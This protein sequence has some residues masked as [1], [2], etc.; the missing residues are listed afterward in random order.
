M[1]LHLKNFGLH[2]QKT[3]EF[4]EK[5]TVLLSGVSGK[6]KTTIFRAIHF[7]LTGESKM[8]THGETKSAVTLEYFH[9]GKLIKITRTNR[10]VR[11]VLEK[12]GKMYEDEEAQGEI[13][14]IFP[15][16]T[17]AGY[18][19][20]KGLN[21]EQRTQYLKQLF[22][23]YKILTR[24]QVTEIAKINPVTANKDL[25][26]LCEEGFIIKRTP[27]KSYRSNYYEIM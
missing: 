8:V 20:Q 24:G 1:K 22:L 27:T 26:K 16:F 17:I 6:G 23:K 18:I 13:N 19:F 9:E 14:R 5:G 21:T 12:D 7:V 3:F 25:Q 11:V 2:V 15:S 10:P 4:P